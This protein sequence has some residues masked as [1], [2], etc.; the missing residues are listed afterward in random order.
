MYTIGPR[1]H[2]PAV[3]ASK[4]Q[5]T[6]KPRERKRTNDNECAVWPTS[7]LQQGTLLEKQRVFSD[8]EHTVSKK[9]KVSIEKD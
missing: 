9:L 6:T 4:A 7:Q 8:S 1:E 2:A 5:N 3:H